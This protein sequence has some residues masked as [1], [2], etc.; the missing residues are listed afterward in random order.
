MAPRITASGIPRRLN[1][2]SNYLTLVQGPQLATRIDNCKRFHRVVDSFVESRELWN[3]PKDA[4]NSV[5]LEPHQN[6]CLRE[7]ARKAPIVQIDSLD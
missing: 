1:R 7:N 4:K 2:Q 3:V 5:L 6:Y